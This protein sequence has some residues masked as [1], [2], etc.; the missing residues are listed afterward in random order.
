MINGRTRVL[1]KVLEKVII[2]KF[3]ASTGFIR[4]NYYATGE[5][6]SNFRFSG[7]YGAEMSKNVYIVRRN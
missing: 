7:K 2:S 1:E 6:A 3:C 5:R 4:V